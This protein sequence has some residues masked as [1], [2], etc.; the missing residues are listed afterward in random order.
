VRQAE[1]RLSTEQ[2]QDTIR[3][4]VDNGR[5]PKWAIPERIEFV[6]SLPKT[7]VGKMDKKLMRNQWGQTPLVLKG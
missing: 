4:Q 2:I 3:E 5:L 1:A 6:E 7:S